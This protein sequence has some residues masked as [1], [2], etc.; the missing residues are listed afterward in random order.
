[1]KMWYK[2]TMGFYP[3]T[4]NDEILPFSITYTNLVGSVLSEISQTN[5]ARYHLHVESKK[6]G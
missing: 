2:C 6:K 1:M 5:T 4:K 3:T